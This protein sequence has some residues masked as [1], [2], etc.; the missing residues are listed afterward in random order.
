MAGLAAELKDLFE[1][2]KMGALDEAE[3]VEAKNMVLRKHQGSKEGG[4]PD[5]PAEAEPAAPAPTSEAPGEVFGV[6]PPPAPVEPT[7]VHPPPAPST[8]EEAAPAVDT[9]RGKRR[10]AGGGPPAKRVKTEGGAVAAGDEGGAWP[11]CLLGEKGGEAAAA[12]VP[13]P[14]EE[15]GAGTPA[16]E[17]E[18]AAP[19]ARA[20]RSGA[21]DEGVVVRWVLNK[22]F[23]FI[24]S[25]SY[26]NKDFYVHYANFKGGDL[27]V[28]QKC[29]FRAKDPARS[30][31]VD[32][33]EVIDDGAAPPLNKELLGH[34][35]NYNDKAKQGHI[36][37]LDYPTE[38][39]A[40]KSAS[41]V[42]SAETMPLVALGRAVRFKVKSA[43][44]TS[45]RRLIAHNVE[46]LTEK[47]TENPRVPLPLG[48]AYGIIHSFDGEQQ[49]GVVRC[50]GEVFPFGEEAVGQVHRGMPRVCENA[51]FR[52]KGDNNG[53]GRCVD[54]WQSLIPPEG[55]LQRGRLVDWVFS[56]DRHREMGFVAIPEYP[57]R[58]VPVFF[59]D[60]TRG[61]TPSIAQDVWFRLVLTDRGPV[62]RDVTLVQP[63][64]W[65]D[66]GSVAGGAA[67]VV[68]AAA[69]AGF[70]EALAG[71]VRRHSPYGVHFAAGR[72]S[73]LKEQIVAEVILAMGAT[74][75]EE[76]KKKIQ[77]DVGLQV[78]LAREAWN[79]EHG[80]VPS[81]KKKPWGGP[82][83]QPTPW[84]NGSYL[85]RRSR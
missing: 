46:P 75:S 62:A 71:A 50:R 37:C 36:V 14:K 85:E 27:M 45:R 76:E 15:A 22:G 73:W 32:A 2:K 53:G 64:E 10:T 84:H 23:G 80:R 39:I 47:E 24:R 59:Q 29:R 16:A 49:R 1:L 52:F 18:A 25:P 57:G 20:G 38:R 13:S 33:F 42:G 21:M 83:G 65:V 66:P 40:F 3:F 60:F 26:P 4:Q 30:E 6:S 67:P 43:D 81:P 44:G 35:E 11:L 74:P 51:I 8:A 68:R 55:S 54:V 72:T 48:Y 69:K 56:R 58:M 28:G 5:A 31:R 17:A 19:A 61:R 12:P 70:E 41:V 34:I 9:N 79:E 82:P 78:S 7:P 77:R 63:K